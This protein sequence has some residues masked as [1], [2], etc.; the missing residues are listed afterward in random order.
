[1]SDKDTLFSKKNLRLLTD[2]L[3]QFKTRLPFRYW[4]LFGFGSNCTT[5][6]GHCNGHIGYGGNGTCRM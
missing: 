2:P 4:Y 3:K 1:M 5:E 6:T